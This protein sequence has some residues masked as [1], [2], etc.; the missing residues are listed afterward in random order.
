M[1]YYVN[2]FYKFF[3][4]AVLIPMLVLVV[5]DFSRKM[6]NRFSKPKPV[7]VEKSAVKTKKS[8]PADKE[9]RHD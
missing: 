8:T 7:E 6:I 2:L 4:P 3:I 1:V 9:S 5:M